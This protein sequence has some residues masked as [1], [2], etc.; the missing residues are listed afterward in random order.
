[1]HVLRGIVH[2]RRPRGERVAIWGHGWRNRGTYWESILMTV[3]ILSSSLFESGRLLVRSTWGEGGSATRP[4]VGSG[5]TR[6]R[7]TAAR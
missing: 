7:T 3:F 4:P 1:M 5:R 2:I 6:V